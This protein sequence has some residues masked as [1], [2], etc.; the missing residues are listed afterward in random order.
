MKTDLISIVIPIYNCEDYIEEC[1]NSIL[2]QSYS[3]WELLLINDGS[4]DNSGII[5][6]EFSNKDKR[7]RYFEKK[8]GGVSSARNYGIKYA[9]GKWIIFVDSD[10][11][12]STDFLYHLIK[13]N[14]GDPYTHVIQGF[15]CID[16][17]G[18]LRKWMDIDYNGEYFE[19]NKIEPYLIKYDLINRVQIWGK[20]FS[21]DII[22]QNNLYFNENI[23]LGED[24]I[25]S[26]K[27]LLLI[28]RI[29]LS[30]Y[31]E[32]LY[33]NPFLLNRDNL[34]K[35][36]KNIKELYHLT[37]IYKGLSIMFITKLN[38]QDKNERNKIMNFYISN[39]RL[40]LSNKKLLSELNNNDLNVLRTNID[41]YKP[42]SIKD[43]VFKFLYRLPYKYINKL[44]S[45]IKR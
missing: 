45:V 31:S 23:N 41:Y 20:L 25:F 39:I 24:G 42:I 14:N 19:V 34:T 9:S 3:N 21:T 38:I 29:K 8:N 18:K 1:I 28:K 7:V 35:K 27:Y 10:D 30:K 37:L 5:C 44:Y 2:L 16:E 13:E 11:M 17:N 22:K 40:L 32:Y 4:Q 15:K 33:R 12:I 26:H 6:R 36:I 43:I